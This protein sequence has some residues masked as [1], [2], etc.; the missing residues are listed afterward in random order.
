VARHIRGNPEEVQEVLCVALDR[1]D[2]EDRQ[3]QGLAFAA[4]MAGGSSW[5]KLPTLIKTN[6]E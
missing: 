2:L 3:F 1:A 6:P 4:I 5:L